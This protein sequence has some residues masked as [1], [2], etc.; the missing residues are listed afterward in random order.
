MKTKLKEKESIR[1]N[2][3]ENKK[4]GFWRQSLDYLMLRQWSYD[5]GESRDLSMALNERV[6][7]DP[8]LFAGISSLNLIRNGLSIWKYRVVIDWK[9]PGRDITF[10]FTDENG[11]QY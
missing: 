1:A 11:A 3:N 9:S 7:V 8:E 2:D 6:D 5:E 10:K 4:R